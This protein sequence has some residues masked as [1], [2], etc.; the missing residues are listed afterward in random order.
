MLDKIEIKLTQMVEKLYNK[1]VDNNENLMIKNPKLKNRIT[2][3]KHHN[4][5]N[6]GTNALQNGGGGSWFEVQ[7]T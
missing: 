6:I 7:V 1:L 3:I 4:V 2:N 5:K